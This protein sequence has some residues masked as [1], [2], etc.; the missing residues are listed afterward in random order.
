MATGGN[1]QSIKSLLADV[2]QFSIPDFQRNYAWENSQIDDF[3]TDVSS[4]I[5][6][7]RQHFIGA[8][9]LLSKSA[10]G[11]VK[12]TYEVIDGQ[13]RLTTIFMY[14]S[15]LRD[16]A[17][18]Q[19]EIRID[20]PNPGGMPIDV[21]SRIGDLIF[22]D[23]GTGKPRF[24]SNRL[25]RTMFRERIIAHP[26]A[27]RPKMPVR[28][29]ASTLPLRKAYARL[30]THL[31]SELAKIDTPIDRLKRIYEIFET[32]AGS[33]NLLC[34]FTDT[35]SEAFDIFMTLNNRGRALGPADLVKTLL[36]KYLTDG[37]TEENLLKTTERISDDWERITS[38]IELGDIDQFL[39]HFMLSIQ[40]QAVQSKNIYSSFDKHISEQNQVLLSP[41]EIKTRATQM[42]KQLEKASEV[43]KKLLQPSLITDVRIRRSAQSML[44]VLVSYRILMMRVISE[45]SGYTVTQQREI[46]RLT[47]VLS[48]RWVLV[49]GNAQEL[50]DH[51]QS[52]C[53][54]HRDSAKS[55]EDLKTLLTS[56][57]PD[58]ERVKRAFSDP[59]SA[60]MARAV[61]Y[62]INVQL[63]DPAALLLYEPARLQ[64]EHIAPA[65]QT[66]PWIQA[67][68]GPPFEGVDRSIE[69]SSKTEAWGNK[70]L[71]ESDIN[72]VI[73]QSLFP[74]KR[75]GNSEEEWLG[76]RHSVLAVTRDLQEI[77][78]WTIKEI[79]LR[80]KWA[81]ESFL[82]IWDVSPDLQGVLDYSEWRKSENL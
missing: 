14:L 57:I 6:L 82:K 26:T 73:K 58:N 17:V 7:K 20:P 28:D 38:N 3:L 68:Y 50:E 23:P 24:Q 5:R 81:S 21:M 74:V 64:V 69:Y 13:Q 76:Y 41:D 11:D 53:A 27:E 33:F 36:M 15:I 32:V 65:T 19:G 30:K 42:L 48:L 45:E 55:F 44:Q 12:K 16:A 1:V 39:R 72:N 51:F 78:E 59:V 2:E 29:K 18:A 67:L 10:P 75:D 79:D 62:G 61:Y 22:S 46:S 56:K 40:D 52:V 8:L 34:I 71:L 70:T 60:E 25:L 63:G 35:Y 47:E 80:S 54:T 37:E 77:D 66:D 49:G 31:E 43:Y 9:I 4:A